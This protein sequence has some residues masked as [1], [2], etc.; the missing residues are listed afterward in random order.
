M[1]HNSKV[2]DR[3]IKYEQKQQF[4]WTSQSKFHGCQGFPQ[5]GGLYKYVSVFGMK[6]IVS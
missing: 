6:E 3:G 5:G 4:T 2:V 1:E